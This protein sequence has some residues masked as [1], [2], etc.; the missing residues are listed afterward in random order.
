MTTHDPALEEFLLALYRTLG[1]RA[2]FDAFLDPDLTVWESA[3]PRLLRGIAELDEL[4]GPAVDPGQRT[5]P[6][7][8]VLPVDIVAESWGDTGLIRAVLEVRAA[9]NG[10]LV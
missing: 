4:R 2:A 9:A 10:P 3:D 8:H 7:P 5:R 1:D 6:L